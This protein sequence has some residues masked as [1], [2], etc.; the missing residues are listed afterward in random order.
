[1]I[2]IQLLQHGSSLL[3]AGTTTSCSI[4]RFLL[5]SLIFLS[6]CIIVSSLAG[7]LVGGWMKWSDTI[8]L[9]LVNCL[10][11]DLLQ[12]FLLLRRLFNQPL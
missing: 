12:D 9:R 1:M 10:F 11:N 2:D 5:R 8:D 6:E 4:L 3:T 7:D